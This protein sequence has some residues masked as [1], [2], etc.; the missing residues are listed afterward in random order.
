MGDAF[1][2]PSVVNPPLP[3]TLIDR[4]QE[5]P[6]LLTRRAFAGRFNIWR[7]RKLMTPQTLQEWTFHHVPMFATR[8]RDVNNSLLAAA[9]RGVTLYEP[10]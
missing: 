3:M 5:I 7:L 2:V 6:F 10:E 9:R 4:G 1:P 8:A